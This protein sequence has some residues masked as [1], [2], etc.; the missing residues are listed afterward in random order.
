MYHQ[1]SCLQPDTSILLVEAA[2]WP[3][4]NGTEFCIDRMVVRRILQSLN[5]YASAGPQQKQLI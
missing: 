4:D 2:C 5:T 3:F 1:V